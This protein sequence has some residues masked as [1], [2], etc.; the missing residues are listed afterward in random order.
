MGGVCGMN[1]EENV[2]RSLLGNPERRR[3]LGK[4]RRR[5]VNKMKM[6]LIGIGRAD[7]VWPRKESSGELL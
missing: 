2:Y 7:L 3:Q 1:G 5:C 6:D 4:P